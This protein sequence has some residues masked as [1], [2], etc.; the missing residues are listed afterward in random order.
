MS[1][2]IESILATAI[3]LMASA[4]FVALLAE[5]DHKPAAWI[6]GTWFMVNVCLS[7]SMFTEYLASTLAH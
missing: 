6:M 3:A 7:A 4:Y 2:E 5:D 1:I